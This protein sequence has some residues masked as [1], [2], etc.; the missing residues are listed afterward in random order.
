MKIAVALGTDHRGYALKEFLKEYKAIGTFEINW[1]DQGA[2]N[3]ERSDYPKFAQAVCK[4]VRW[5]DADVGILLC[6]TGAGMTIAANRFEGIFAGLVWSVELAR[7][8]REDDNCNV[9]VIP[10][11]YIDQFLLVGIIE[12]WLTAEFKQGRYADR[13]AQIDQIK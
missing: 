6:G 3:D 8:A 13:L 11:D 9:L 10:A 4:D 1:L 7:L 2:F 5:G 12:A